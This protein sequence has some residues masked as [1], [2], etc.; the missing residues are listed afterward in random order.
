MR[1][2]GYRVVDLVVEHL[3]TRNGSPAILC[4]SAETLFSQLG[5]SLPELPG[6][7]DANLEL[8]AHVA[9]AHQQHSDHPRYFARVPGP[10]SYAAILGEWLATGFN[11][12]AASW[13]GGSGPTSVELVVVDWLRDILHL[14]LTTEG[15]FVSGGSLANL[16]AISAARAKCGIG[17]VYLSDQTHSSVNRALQQMNFPSELIRVLESDPNL[18]MPADGLET[19]IRDDLAHGRTP[20]MVVATAGTTNSGAIDPLDAIASLCRY[21]DLWLHVDGAYG[22]PAAFCPEGHQLLSGIEL[23]DSIAIDPHKWLFQPYDIGCTL[24]TRPGALEGAYAMNPEYLKDVMARP[25][26]VDLRN[27][28]LEL[29][30]RS[31][32]IKLWMTF[33]TYGIGRI[34]EAIQAGMN[35]A[36]YAEA[37]LRESPEVWEVVTGAQLGIVTF[38]FKG[39][40][41]R[42]H[43]FS[44][45]SLSDSG[46]AAVTSTS[47][48]GASVLRL[49]TINPLT[50][51][52]DIRQTLASL[53]DYHHKICREPA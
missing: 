11:S 38:R 37:V 5:G 27:R 43:E 22:A 53:A 41:Q 20:M 35:L 44:A 6:D 31:R 12:I 14:P 33:R 42:D 30:R 49:C 24:V 9:L 4:A 51:E 45:Q 19:V 16:T 13:A 23:A 2:L 26:E 25:G 10:S 46:Y 52:N 3:S 21:Y 15:V 17:V 48:K 36:H 8:L 40:T 7:A 32:A 18:R 29:S 47:L 39:G 28:S 34:R 50:T 1:R